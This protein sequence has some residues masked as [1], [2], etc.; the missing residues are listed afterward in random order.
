[1]LAKLFKKELAGIYF[2]S[3][4]LVIVQQGSGRV[5]NQLC[6]P[7]PSFGPEAG[8]ALVEDIFEIF[9]NRDDEL[10]AFM[11]KAIRDSKVDT[12]NVVVALPPKD[13]IIRFFEMPNIPKSEVVAGINFEMKKYIPFKIEE[14]AYDFQYRV[15]QKANVIEVILCGMRQDPLDRYV[16]LFKQL[17]L[18]VLAFE[19]GLFSLFRL[20][21]IKNKISSL[22]SY[23]ILEFDKEEANI[24]IAEKGFSYFTRDIKLVSAKAGAKTQDEFDTIVFRLINEVRVSL[25]YYRRQFLRKDVDE[26]IAISSK[27]F[28]GLVDNFSKELGLKVSFIALNDL[29]KLKDAPDEMLSDASKALGAALRIERPSLVTLNL[30]RTK[31]RAEKISLAFAGVAGENLQQ[32]V[33]NFVRESKAALT[34]GLI[35]GAIIFLIGYGLGFSKLFPLEKEFAAATVK[36]PPLLPGVDV[37]SLDTV[38]SSESTFQDKEIDLSGLIDDYAPF[39][40]KLIL[41][42]RLLPTGV[43]LNS[44]TYTVLPLSLD[45][46]CASY[47]EDEKERSDNINKFVLS[48]RENKEFKKDLS[49]VDLRSYRETIAPGNVYYMQFDVHCEKKG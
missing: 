5:M 2:S 3:K 16:N 45:L 26:L 31:E 35:A 20:L 23:V 48:L 30:G 27:G 34:K 25:D 43:W 37:T 9:K 29:L 24:M 38:K 17:S 47:A 8:G 40:K 32:V 12:K 4:G 36:Q 41:L 39:Y 49:F 10:M 15:K 6:V 46:N 21:V 28:S 33:A 18:N 22:H 44:F 1:M 42:A 11:Q 19:P 14:L 13:L 7:Y